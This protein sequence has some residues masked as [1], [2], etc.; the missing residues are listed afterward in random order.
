M[1]WP[2]SSTGCQPKRVRPLQ[3]RLDAALAVEGRRTQVVE[4]EAELLVLGADAPV[5]FRLFAGRD[6]VDQLARGR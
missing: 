6:V 4:A 1:A 2:C 3:Q 5:G